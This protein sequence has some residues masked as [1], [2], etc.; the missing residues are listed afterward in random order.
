MASPLKNSI[1]L[2]GAGPVGCTVARVLAELGYQCHILEARDHI[3][4]NCY[5]TFDKHGVLIH[6]YGPHCF[7]T[8]DDEVFQFLSRFTKWIPSE[9]IVKSQINDELFQFPIN[10]ETL[11]Q[12]FSKKL[13]KE[14]AAELLEELRDNSITQ[15]AN[16]EE[17]VLSRIGKRLF[18]MFYKDYTSKQWGRPASELSPSVCGRI[19]VRLDR[20]PGYVEAKHL[21]TPEEGFTALFKKMIDHPN[22]K[23]TLNCAKDHWREE[24]PRHQA[25]VYTGTIDS[26]FDYKIGKLDWRSLS[27][28]FKNY[29]TEL[30]QPCLQIN[31]PSKD[32]EY[33]RSVEIKHI[34]KQKISST[35]V[36]YEY[37]K[38]KGEPYY[39]VPAPKNQELYAKYQ[40]LAEQELKERFVYFCGRLAEYTYINSDEAVKKALDLSAKIKDQLS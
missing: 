12:V 37:P 36:S 26:Y 15:P 31:Y 16:S 3:A 39:P 38:S 24:L 32:F 11:E 23:L 35:T 34:T 8:D 2:V 18:E 27:F 29:Q 22:I 21:C 1:L 33:T 20:Y 13:D 30:K 10:I 28:E 17:F 6:K 4:G 14:S 40:E 5:D 25:T 19:P 7:R 9:Y